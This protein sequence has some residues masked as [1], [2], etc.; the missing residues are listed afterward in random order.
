MLPQGGVHSYVVQRHTRLSCAYTNCHAFCSQVGSHGRDTLGI[1]R[2]H[3]FEKVEQFCVTV[4]DGDESWKMQE[5]MLANSEEFYK[6]LGLPYRV[7]RAPRRPLP[8]VAKA[9]RPVLPSRCCV[10]APCP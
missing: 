10:G 4:P 3:Q 2:V 9:H 6:S 5:E 1:F 7:A 8:P